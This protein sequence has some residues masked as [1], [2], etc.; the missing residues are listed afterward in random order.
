MRSWYRDYV[1]ENEEIACNGCKQENWCRHQMIKC[2]ADRG[3][4][5][6]GEYVEYNCATLKECIEVTGLLSR[7]AGRRYK[8]GIWATEKSVHWKRKESWVIL[9]VFYQIQTFGLLDSCCFGKTVIVAF[10]SGLR[11]HQWIT[12]FWYHL[13]LPSIR[14]WRISW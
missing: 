9:I 13:Y 6:C 4:K 12:L 3:V 2:C 8:R 1:V 14:K 10:N 5:N 7:C 11:A